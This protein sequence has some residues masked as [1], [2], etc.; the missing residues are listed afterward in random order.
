M[1]T[2]IVPS[3]A[4]KRGRNSSVILTDRL[5]EKRVSKR[6]KF[7]DRKCPGLYVSITTAGIAT[8]SF[9]FTDRQTGKQRTGWLGVYNPETFTV[10]DA[11][12]KVYGLKTLGGDALLETFRDQ[13]ATKAKRGKTV[14]EIIDERIKWM[15]T[16]VKKPDGEMRPRLEAW[17]HTAS[18]LNRFIRPRLGKKLAMEVTKHD[19]ATLSNDIVEGKFGKPSV[20]NARHMRKAASGLFNWAAEA[21]RDYVTASPCVN[22]PK[23]D[24]E[25]PRTRVLSEDE[26]RT[27]WHGL[28]RDDLPYDRRTRLALKFELVTMLRSRELLGAHRDELFDL[29]GEHP[30][31]D[32]PL[33][34]VKKRRVI[35]QPLSDLAVEI[36]KEALVSDDQEYVFESPMYKGQPIHRKAMADALRGTMNE[37]CKGKTKTPGICDLL[38]L[39]R[40]TPHDLRRTAATLAGDLGFDDAVIARCLDHAVSR[41][42]DVIVPTVTGKVY[43]HSKRMKEKRAVLDGVA[44]E[45]R[46]IIGTSSEARLR[47][48]A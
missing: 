16:P 12:S 24:P 5:C 11:R 21:G 22:L 47:L 25:H 2:T 48:V 34:R 18:H 3:P 17:E 19:I 33:K 36:I 26:I 7:Y 6:T 46:R 20:S 27:F 1:D 31:F 23:L 9:K 29:E 42:G 41:K 4:G 10:E 15:K 45:L 38:G 40:F 13:K 28:E 43:N 32:V 39:K 8:F 37:K 30:R 14:A 44:A 35:Q